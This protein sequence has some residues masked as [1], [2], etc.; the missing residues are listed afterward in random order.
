M[1]K[2]Y[3]E[4]LSRFNGGNSNPFYVVAFARSTGEMCIDEAPKFCGGEMFVRMED[5]ISLANRSSCNI[6]CCKKD[7]ISFHKAMKCMDVLRAK[8]DYIENYE[9]NGKYNRNALEMEVFKVLYKISE[10][11]EI[12]DLDNLKFHFELPSTPD[13]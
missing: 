3:E 4:L 5:W 11:T 1:E 7:H 9:K 12:A 10:V 6:E 8:N 13:A 2:S